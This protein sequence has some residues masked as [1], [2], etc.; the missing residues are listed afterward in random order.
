MSENDHTDIEIRLERVRERIRVAC[1]KAGRDPASVH[2]LAVGKKKP[3][4]LI[5]EAHQA[6]QVDFGENYVQELLAKQEILNLPVKWHFIGRMQT[7]KVRQIVGKVEMIHAV[8]SIKLAKE[9]EKRANNAAIT[10]DVLM[11]VN[12]GEEVSKSGVAPENV[13][14]LARFLLELPHVRWRGLMCLPPFGIDPETARPHFELL[15]SIRDRLQDDLGV[16]LEELSMG[17]SGDLEVAIECGATWVRVGTDIF[18]P[19]I[20]EG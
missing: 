16:A 17:M 2:L 11:M 18:G 5:V 7:N 14:E 10:T 12:T 8:D 6:G 3:A 1:E 4:E 19:R 9:I 20:V 13:D 15:G